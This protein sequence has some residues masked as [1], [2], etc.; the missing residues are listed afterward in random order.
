MRDSY[1]DLLWDKFSGY[2]PEPT[3]PVYPPYH[4]GDYLE[5]YFMKRFMEDPDGFERYFIPVGWTTS[6]I[7]DKT[8]GLQDL[9]NELD[10]DKKYFTVAQHDD[11]IREK[12]PPDTISFNAGGN[13]SHSS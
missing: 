13:K 9:L 11:A 3:Y 8:G 12:L 5:D 7:E 2:R 6:Y 10:P 4:N 1:Q